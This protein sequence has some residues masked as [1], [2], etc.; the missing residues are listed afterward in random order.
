MSSQGM[1]AFSKEGGGRGSTLLEGVVG[2]GKSIWGVYLEKG[3]HGG[4]D[5]RELGSRKRDILRGGKKRRVDG[6]ESH[7]TSMRRL[8]GNG[9]WWQ[10]IPTFGSH[11]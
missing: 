4:L 7:R 11:D 8:A 2:G 10:V 6:L 1:K 5:W 3:E 9:D